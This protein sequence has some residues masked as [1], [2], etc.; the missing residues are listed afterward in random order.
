MMMKNI[1]P[2]YHLGKLGTKNTYSVNEKEKRKR[3]P[4]IDGKSSSYEAQ[5]LT[6]ITFY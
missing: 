4:W 6:I 2:I 3:L 5:T 1:L